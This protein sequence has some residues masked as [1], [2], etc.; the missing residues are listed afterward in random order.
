MSV[1]YVSQEVCEGGLV[2]IVLDRLKSPELRND[3]MYQSLTCQA[4]RCEVNG[5]QLGFSHG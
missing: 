1:V 4:Y 5:A 3:S 2:L